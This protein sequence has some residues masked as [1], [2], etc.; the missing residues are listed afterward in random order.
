MAGAARSSSSAWH[1]SQLRVAKLD[2]R[3]Y[4][5]ETIDFGLEGF[6]NPTPLLWS[7]RSVAQFAGADFEPANVREPRKPTL[8]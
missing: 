7:K 6:A 5:A 4:A 8:R 1:G 3:G 2:L